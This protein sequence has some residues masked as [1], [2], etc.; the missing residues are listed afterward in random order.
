MSLHPVGRLLGVP[1]IP[2][3]VTRVNIALVRM[4]PDKLALVRMASVKS[5]FS[6]SNPEKFCPVRS[7]LTK[8]ADFPTI[9]PFFHTQPVGNVGAGVPVITCPDLMP[10]S[11][12]VDRSVPVTVA[13]TTLAFVRLMFVKFAL[14]RLAPDSTELVR[15]APEKLTRTSSVPAK[16]IPVRL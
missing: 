10:V 11:V 15:L 3:D 16:L 12:A 6:K 2:P 5:A 7:A 9:Y 1:T 4:V 8:L 14:V 13:L